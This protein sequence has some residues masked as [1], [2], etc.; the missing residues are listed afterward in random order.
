LNS[1]KTE[2]GFL[3]SELKEI[4]IFASMI[5]KVWQPKTASGC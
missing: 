4:I 3:I 5:L 1:G 2:I